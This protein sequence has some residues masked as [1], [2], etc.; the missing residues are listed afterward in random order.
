MELINAVHRYLSGFI[1]S[2]RGFGREG[3]Q[4][5]LNLFSFY[6]NTP[7]DA[8]EKAQAFIEMA[9]KK[10]KIMRYRVWAKG[11]NVDKN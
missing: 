1:R 7:G 5:W 11:E 2:R 8:F 3:L 9:V 6:W 10:R 4:G